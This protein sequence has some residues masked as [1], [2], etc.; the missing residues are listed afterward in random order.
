NLVSYDSITYKLIDNITNSVVTPDVD[1]A[2]YEVAEETA[3]EPQE[4]INMPSGY[5]RNITFTKSLVCTITLT[6]DVAGFILKNVGTVAST[7]NVDITMKIS[8][9]HQENP[10][11]YQRSVDIFKTSN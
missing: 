10:S 4:L 2:H 7:T 9:R 11:I 1:T 6:V 5:G 8:N 3:T